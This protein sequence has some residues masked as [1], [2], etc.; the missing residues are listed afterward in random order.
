MREIAIYGKGGIGKSTLTANLSAA[1]ALRGERVLQIGCDPKHDST[2]LLMHGK[3]ITTVLDYIRDTAALDQKR[4]DILFTGF[5][6]TGCIEA[7]GPKPGV[8]CAGRGIITAFELLDRF[9]IKENYDV[10]MYDVLGDVV[11][12]GFAVPIRRE[13]ANEIFVVTSGEYMSIYAA[14]NILRGIKNYDTDTARIAGIIYNSRNVVGEK[15]RV[16]K[17]ADAVGLPVFAEV[18]RSEIFAECERRDM[19]AVEMMQAGKDSSGMATDAGDAKGFD[20]IDGLENVAAIF[21]GMAKRISEGMQHYQADPLTDEELE[22]LIMGTK[23]IEGGSG[24]K[25]TEAVTTLGSGSETANT[26]TADNKS[27]NAETATDKTANTETTNAKDATTNAAA[28]TV[29]ANSDAVPLSKN[30]I[31][32][33]PLH[34]CAFNGAVC[35]SVH[36]NDAKVLMHAPKSCA[37]ISWQTVSS[38]GRRALYERGALLPSALLPDMEATNMTESDMVFG[39]TDKLMEH[40]SGI[41]NSP[42]H[43]K[44]LIVIS[45]CP[46]GIIGDDIDRVKSLSTS[47]C[48]VIT[49]KTDGNLTGDYLQGMLM[50]YT[51]LAKQIVDPEIKPEPDT[52]NIVFEKV[53]IKNDESNFSVIRSFLDAMHIKVNCRFLYNTSYESVRRFCSAELNLLAYKDYT[54]NIL[55]D[56]FTKN[57]GAKFFG[58][59]FPVGYEETEEWIRG[60]AEHFGRQKEAEDLITEN[61][62]IYYSRIRELRPALEGKKLLIITF[63]HEIDWILRA[64]LDCGMVI[65]KICVLN[66]SQDEGFRTRIPEVKDIEVVEDYDREQRINDIEELKPDIVLGNY[67]TEKIKH[68]CIFDNIPMCP[69]VGFFPGLNMVER[70][71]GLFGSDNEGEW[72]N[73]R[74]LFE[75]YHA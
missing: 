58:M 30:V 51:E 4:E 8:G 50:A 43:P 66:F 29:P 59:Q 48:R 74:E 49:V 67:T 38:T 60:I 47:D 1:M 36:I 18:P 24:N 72:Q 62:N 6:G 64:A 44:A 3:R 22:T 57:Y 33:E 73:D 61:R 54:G 11:C 14:N 15:E 16:Q 19:T 37:Y 39:G 28:A 69:D 21:T 13:Y 71:S 20:S 2:R 25:S 75:K 7:G 32:D 53:V 41:V 55:Q 52:V 68:K 65:Q 23:F 31:R 56:F 9:H 35:M 63:N 46:A 45:A 17:F 70:W 42:E 26:E 34:G 5:G 12:G 40:V 10:I 27:A